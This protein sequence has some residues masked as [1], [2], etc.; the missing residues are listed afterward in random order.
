[1]RSLI[2]RVVNGCAPMTNRRPADQCPASNRHDDLTELLVRFQVAVSF[3]NFLERERLDDDWLQYD[4]QIR[5]C[6]EPPGALSWPRP[7]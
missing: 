4:D 2:H 1:V 5:L 6:S 3:N 7:P